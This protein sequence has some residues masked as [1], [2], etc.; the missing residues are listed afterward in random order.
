MFLSVHALKVGERAGSIKRIPV[1]HTHTHTHTH[2]NICTHAR[3]YT[4]T[5]AH[6]HTHTLGAVGLKN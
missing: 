6:T 5:H 3:T 2:T 4:H 1:T